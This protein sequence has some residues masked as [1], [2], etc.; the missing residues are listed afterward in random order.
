MRTRSLMQAS[1]LPF[2]LVLFASTAAAQPSRANECDS[3]HSSQNISQN[4]SD[5]ES[6]TWRVSWESN[7]CSVDMRSKGDVKFSTDLTQV[8]SISRGGYFEITER[9]AG[10][11]RHYEATPRSGGGLDEEYS[12]NGSVRPLDEAGKTWVRSVILELERHSGF[13]AEWRVGEILRKSGVDGVLT[14]VATLSSDYVQRRYLNVLMDS[15]TLNDGQ[16]RRVLQIAGKGIDSDYELASLLIDLGKNGY[17]KPTTSTEYVQAASTLQSDY[18]RRRALSALLKV[19][20]LDR[21]VY[22]TILDVAGDISSD[23]ELAS[24]L[25]EMGP[26]GLSTPEMRAAYFKAA[27]SLSSDYEHR[28]AFS[29]LVKSPEL[30]KELLTAILKSATDISSDYELA[31]LLVEIAGRHELDGELRDAYIRAADGISSD[32]EHRRALS[33]LIKQTGKGRL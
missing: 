24:L 33:A 10:T 31:S 16:V 26:N 2:A 30:S 15:T 20:G 18:E 9:V 27:S 22:K 12:V 17:V 32:S 5:S 25:I 3:E 28:R 6:R 11:K 13:A 4:S 29:A 7:E 19:P 21:G 23:Y 8:L 1:V 14:E